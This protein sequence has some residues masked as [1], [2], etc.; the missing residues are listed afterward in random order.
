MFNTELKRIG[1]H[2]NSR[3]VYVTKECRKYGLDEDDEMFVLT[4]PASDKDEILSRLHGPGSMYFVVCVK[5]AGKA[6][7]EVRQAESEIAL[8]ESVGK[9]LITVL[10]PFSS[11]EE[12]RGLKLALE[13][14][15]A[16]AS[17]VSLKA[18]L[19]KHLGC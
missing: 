13:E 7:Y 19:R 10:G 14:S 11:L 1:V 8:A 12:A 3:I 6:L 9:G 15:D 17:E 4:A 2:G 5:K 16:E 18:F